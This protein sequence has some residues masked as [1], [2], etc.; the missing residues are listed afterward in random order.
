MGGLDTDTNGSE[1]AWRRESGGRARVTES[2]VC[3]SRYNGICAG[4]VKRLGRKC[5]QPR[6]R[7]GG[8]VALQANGYESKASLV[9]LD[10]V[11]EVMED[12]SV[13]KG[14]AKQLVRDA[15][16]MHGVPA[17][18][19]RLHMDADAAPVASKDSWSG[20]EGKLVVEGGDTMV[21]PATRDTLDAYIRMVGY[22]SS[23]Y[24]VHTTAA[25]GKLMADICMSDSNFNALCLTV[26]DHE[27]MQ[28]AAVVASGLPAKVATFLEAEAPMGSGGLE[29]IR[30]LYSPYSKTAFVR[31]KLIRF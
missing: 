8:G 10:D 31:F 23:A 24:C 7:V 25:V 27:S 28:L 20:F 5:C 15:Q 3:R 30:A 13:T 17:A 6:R 4:M 26:G 12:L 18:S 1:R 14:V 19:R 11:A 22:H 9:G 21:M 2:Q 29:V 16:A